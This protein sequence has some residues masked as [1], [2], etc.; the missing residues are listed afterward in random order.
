MKH[1]YALALILMLFGI[2]AFAIW[3]YVDLPI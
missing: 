1:L 3:L 2:V